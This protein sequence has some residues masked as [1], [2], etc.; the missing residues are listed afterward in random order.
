MD[1]SLAAPSPEATPP[2]TP[3]LTVRLSAAE[4]VRLE[5]QFNSDTDRADGALQQVRGR[6]LS[7]EQTQQLKTAQSFLDEARSAMEAQDLQRACTLA[8][9]SRIIAEELKNSLGK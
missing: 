6:L 2:Q 4:Q 3:I 8:E 1:T 5:A 9:K 7:E